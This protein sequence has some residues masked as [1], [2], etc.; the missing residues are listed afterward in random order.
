MKTLSL[1]LP[2]DLARE[3]STQARSRGT[4]KSEILREALAGFLSGTPRSDEGSFLDRAGDLVGRLEGPED[5]SYNKK[6]LDDYG[7]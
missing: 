4:T 6:Y 5:L 3:L 1:K 2:D 7:R